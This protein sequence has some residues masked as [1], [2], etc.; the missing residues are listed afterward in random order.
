MGEAAELIK[1]ILSWP[2]IILVL[3]IFLVVSYRSKMAGWIASLVERIENIRVTSKGVEIDLIK[4]RVEEVNKTVDR[5][6]EDLSNLKVDISQRIDQ[7]L[8]N[9]TEARSS[10]T[11]SAPTFIRFPAISRLI[12]E[13]ETHT[14]E[15]AARTGLNI[16]ESRE[17]VYKEFGVP[18]EDPIAALAHL[19][20][21]IE[22]LVQQLLE[23]TLS[24]EEAKVPSPKFRIFEQA[25][26]LRGRGIISLSVFRAIQ[27]IRD[28]R[29][30]VLHEPERIPTPDEMDEVLAL[31]EWVL[32]SL[33]NSL[34]AQVKQQ[35]AGSGMESLGSRLEHTG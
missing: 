34:A 28:V 18:D 30:R 6:G 11:A 23:A 27:L 19:G 1:A 29:N 20:R 26:L 35:E 2:T 22:H 4:K 32:I 31:G 24:P 21:S 17:K 13:V 16:E 33:N 15:E 5:V 14:K 12:D 8:H 7:V 9:V 10:A 3:F 25:R